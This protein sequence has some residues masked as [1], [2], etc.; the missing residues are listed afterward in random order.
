M[1]L[2]MGLTPSSSAGVVL[3]WREPPSGPRYCRRA[4]GAGNL[5]SKKLENLS[6]VY[7]LL[8]PELNQSSSSS[9]Q[10]RGKKGGKGEAPGGNSGDG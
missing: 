4:G 8:I 9:R 2:R 5:N 1:L 7:S 10:G 6:W 3:S